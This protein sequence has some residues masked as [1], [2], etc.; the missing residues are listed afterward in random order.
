MVAD[1]RKM[2]IIALESQDWVASVM[3]PA[4]VA[5]VQGKML[6]HAQLLDK[7]D[8]LAKVA[9][10]GVKTR[11]QKNIEGFEVHQFFE[12]EAL[13]LFLKSV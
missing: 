2:G 9:G 3:L 13:E 6:I 1:I 8:V 11:S 12:R 10:N 7:K 5:H 4:M